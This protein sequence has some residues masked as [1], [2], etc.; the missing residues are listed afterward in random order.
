M[1]IFNQRHASSRNL[2]VIALRLA[3][4]LLLAPGITLAQVPYSID[5]VVPDPNCCV[6]F[7]DPVGS[8]AELGPINS[9]QTKLGVIDS[10][11]TPMLGFT[12]PSS[13]TDIATIWLDTRKDPTGDIWLYFAW[14]RDA[15]TGSSSISYEFQSEPADPACDYSAIDQTQPESAAETALINSCNPWSNRQAGD[16][17]IVWDFGGGSTQIILREFNGTSFDAGVNLSTSGFAVASLNADSSR[18]EGAINL[19]DAIFD[20]LQRC[21]IFDN[22]IPGTI[23]GNSDS[24]DYKDTVLADV[25]S[26]LNISN[27]GVVDV[28]KVTQPAGE[29]GNFSYTL[30]RL[31]GEDIDFTPNTSATGTLVDDGDSDRLL[32]LPGDNYQLTEDLTGEPTFE[33]QSIKC[34]RPAADTDGTTGFSVSTGETTD[35]VITNELL[36]GT[37]T[38]IKEVVNGFGGTAKPADFCLALN[39][40]ENTPA[41]PGDNTG[42]Q[43]TFAIGNQYSVSEVACGNPDTSPPGYVASLSGACGGVITARTDKTCTVTNTQQEQPQAAFTLFKNVINDNGGS[44]AASAWTLS[45]ALKAG[46]PGTCTAS[47]VSGTDTGSGVGGLLSVSDNIASC[48][49]EIS[50][51]GGPTAGYTAVGWSCAGDVARNGNEITIGSGGGSCTITN[52]DQAPSLVLVKQ[53]TNDN[54]GTVQA[55]AWTLS[56]SGPTP[57]DGAG[58]A[59]SGGSFSAGTYILS[60]FGPDHY[61]ASGWTCTGGSQSGNAITLGLGESATCVIVND[62]IQPVLT[63][64]KSVVNDNGGVLDVGDFALFVGGVPV[65]SGAPNALNAGTYSLTE[66]NLPGYQA[67]AWG[68]DCAADGTVQLT[69]GD[70]KTCTITN[71]DI[72]PELKIVKSAVEIFAMQGGQMAYSIT[73]SNIGGGDALGVTLTDTLPPGANAAENLAPLPWV[74]TTPGCTVTGGGVTLT[75]DIGTLVKDPTPDQVESGDEASFTVDLTVTIPDDYL[76]TAPD[77]PDGSGTLGSRF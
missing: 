50:E 32:V 45:A 11:P 22:V 37:I 5:G 29:A 73:V 12:N 49:Y 74:T 43:F 69:I 68:G 34:S 23:T 15:T 62:D 6:E 48:V 44:V 59:S 1:K 35:C 33:L 47:G 67:G 4:A 39:D 53:V 36:T 21:L 20:R 77:S 46:S 72:P 8:I 71:D 70:N 38:V 54:G 14:E 3:A 19:S 7:Q 9:S 56:A 52:D 42:T 60:E 26:V 63:V 76:E 31:G 55:S 65:V 64:V 75:C 57:I 2:G 27:C 61:T 24:A 25:S 40:D 17:M 51:T 10:A 16:F 66:T 18:G 58:G 13:A 30:Q 28:R 41:F